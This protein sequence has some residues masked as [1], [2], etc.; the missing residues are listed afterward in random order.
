M[1]R[2]SPVKRAGIVARVIANRRFIPHCFCINGTVCGRIELVECVTTT[3]EFYPLFLCA[4]TD[5][6]VANH[7]VLN[8]M[9]WSITSCDDISRLSHQRKREGENHSSRPTVVV[10]ED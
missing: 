4:S 1:E 3:N 9:T 7:T 6:S 2:R 5:V 8:P 10:V